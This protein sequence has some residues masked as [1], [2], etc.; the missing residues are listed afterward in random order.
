MRKSSK[1][2]ITAIIITTFFTISA[3]AQTGVTF[4]NI[5]GD[6]VALSR[7]GATVATGANSFSFFS[8]TSSAVFSKNDISA[9]LSYGQWC[10]D[11]SDNTI[12]NF[13][14]NIKITEKFSIRAGYKNFGYNNITT[15]NSSGVPDDEIKPEEMSAG[16]GVAYKITDKLSMGVNASYIS[17][18]LIYEKGTAISFDLSGTYI[19]NN[20]NIGI[21]A[22]NI[23]SKIKYDN[24]SYDLPSLIKA[25]GQY[26]FN[27]GENSLS[28]NLESDYLLNE[29]TI[30][31]GIGAEFMYKNYLA[32]RAGYHW[33]DEEKT[34]P[35]YASVGLGAKLKYI[36]LN[37]AY[38]L[39]GNNSAPN[40][41]FNISLGITF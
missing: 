7:G 5:P 32:L 19:I 16:I 1:L 22:S 2:L 33:G 6:A 26:T 12:I 10:P 41:G 13:G 29:S 23:G 3:K 20:L 17:S 36:N 4:L 38:I 40:K 37:F 21:S 9:G 18:D 35:S 34:I 28:T 30:S 25:G 11:A 24:N 14:T 15:Y 39:A 31:G 27:L 8:N